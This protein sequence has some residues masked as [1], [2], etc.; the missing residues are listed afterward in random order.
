MMC[1]RLD[2]PALRHLLIAGVGLRNPSAVDQ[3][4]N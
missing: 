2:L 1:D 3:T 4:S